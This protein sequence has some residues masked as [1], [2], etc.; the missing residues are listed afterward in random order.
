M[1]RE[2]KSLPRLFARGVV[3]G[4]IFLFPPAHVVNYQA[5][6]GWACQLADLR[7]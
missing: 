4:I 6:H 7:R 3:N 2:P 5:A 1:V